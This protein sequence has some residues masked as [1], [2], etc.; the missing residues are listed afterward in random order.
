MN[1]KPLVYFDSAATA[2]KPDAVINSITQFYHDEYATVHR[3]VYE[4]AVKSTEM[5]ASVREK[6]RRFINA[7]H[8]EEIIYVKGT[9]EAIN[10]IAASFGKAHIRE[11]DEVIISVMEHHSNIV[12]WQILCEDRKAILKEIPMNDKGELLFEEFEK[13]LTDRTKIVSIGH[14]SNA[15]GTINPIKKFINKTHS[16]GAKIMIDGA[17]SAPHMKLDMQ[18]LDVD[19]YAFSG[20]KLYGPTGVGILYGKKELLED[21]PPYQ[22]GG[23]MVEHVSIAKTT[24]LP[25]PFKFESGT[26][27]I[28]QVIALGVAITY[29]EEIGMDN[30]HQWK[31]RLLETATQKMLEIDEVKII[32]TASQKGGIISFIVNGI[33]P[34]DLGTLLGLRGIA[35]RTGHLCAQPTL[36][37]FK[38]NSIMRISFGLYNT[39]EDIRLF[40]HALKDSIALLKP[41]MSY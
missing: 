36:T 24:Y 37:H 27:L 23:D 9:T 12:P 7:K 35:V 28:A 18:E 26:P 5:Y 41:A 14:L 19:F 8:K 29:L 10:L 3:S 40:I 13:L 34:L 4:L 32:G 6:V 11:G 21:L 25:I 30:I 31:M 22:G 17:Q 39:F 1:G 38:I 33:H 20:H 15:T 16:V 2:H